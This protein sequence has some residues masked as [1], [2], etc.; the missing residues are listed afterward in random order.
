MAKILVIDDEILLIQMVQIRLEANEYE[1]ITAND[2]E[3][4]LEKAKSEKPDLI[5]LDI[6]MPNMD[7]Y[8]VCKLLKTDEQYNKIPI[9]LFT[10]ST[11]DDI[12][13]TSKKVGAD[14]LIR[15]PFDPPVFLAKIKE[16][17][18]KS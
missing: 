2:G 16:L 8:Q 14:A 13:E 7:G 1:V 3:E 5:I 4:G 10:G 15:K 12:E 18:E 9:I 17:L 6:M 11:A